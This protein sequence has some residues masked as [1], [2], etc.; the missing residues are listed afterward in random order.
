[1]IIGQDL[2]IEKDEDRVKE[3]NPIVSYSSD[4]VHQIN[5]RR[6]N[7]CGQHRI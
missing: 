4:E 2:T 5:L 1:M 6:F 3:I 7:Y